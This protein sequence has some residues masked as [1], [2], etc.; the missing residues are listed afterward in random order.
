MAEK[1][2][3]VVEVV[4]TPVEDGL[5]AITGADVWLA[6]VTDRVAAAIEGVTA[7]E[8]IETDAERKA[9]YAKRGDLNRVIKEIE[10]D[11]K[12]QTKAIEDAVKAFKGRA[13]EAE[14]PIKA[15]VAEFG[16]AIDEYDSG[17]AERRLA[18][19]RA[20][21]DA[22]DIT[23][24]VSFDTLVDVRG[25]AWTLRSTGDKKAKAMALAAIDDV[26]SEISV[27]GETFRDDEDVL[28]DALIEY[29]RTLDLKGS[30]DDAKQRAK[31]REGV[32]AVIPASEPEPQP[33]PEPVAQVPEPQPEP[34]AQVPAPQP[35]PTAQVSVP[36]P[37]A[38][39]WQEGAVI[40]NVPE[41]VRTGIA[42]DGEVYHITI[43]FDGTLR[44][45]R[46]VT[47][48]MG[49]HDIGANR[50]RTVSEIG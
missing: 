20:A 35:E 27:L 19:I 46:E 13:A 11:R 33:E 48:F 34:V 28:T 17:F 5:S 47:G 3:D 12:A 49:A 39:T 50:T 8:S 21:Y 40:H 24:V 44:E 38:A 22:S 14:E 16:R 45:L 6:G 2:K 42:R 10:G 31:E 43:E 37:S 30:I 1:K 7:P 36:Q 32:S 25:H 15:L 41:P 4:A 29:G 26:A 23:S 18:D 9:A